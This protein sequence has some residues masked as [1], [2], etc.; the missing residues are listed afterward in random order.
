MWVERPVW[1]GFG[2]CA[3]FVML[4]WATEINVCGSRKA[5]NDNEW[6]GWRCVTIDTSTLFIRFR[7]RTSVVSVVMFL[8]VCTCVCGLVS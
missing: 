4:D 3:V 5:A 8:C 7:Q 1:D 2:M 6:F